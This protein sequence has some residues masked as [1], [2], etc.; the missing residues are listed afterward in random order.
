[1]GSV[2]GIYRLEGMSCASCAGSIQT[3]LSATEGIRE[4]SVN[5]ASEQVMVEYDPAVIPLEAI[6]KAVESLGFKMITRDLSTEEESDLVTRRLGLLKRRTVASAVLT[7]P[8][9][10]LAMVF[11]HLPYANPVMLILTLP[12]LVWS[13][14]EFFVI[15]WKRMVHRSA[16]MDT[17]VALGT[18][19]AFT[20][21]LFNT[22]FPSWLRARGI[23]PHVY[24]EAASVIITFILLGR[25][26]EEK[27]KQKTSGAIKQLMGLGVK[28]ARVVRNGVEKEM[29]ITKIVKG[30][31]LIIR[32][33][34]KI[35]VD[36]RVT[37]G[38]SSVD[39]SMITGESVPVNK[40]PG[41]RVIGATINHTGSLTMVA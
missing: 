39:E 16:N 29:L 35:P 37:E 19:S 15:A 1:M 11:H 21:S 3:L 30:D 20:L 31:V 38:F 2:K 18:G 12:V 14:R 17:L 27:A 41:E 33:G 24:Y 6:T 22:L 25:Y 8:V 4:A 10:I 40:W 23:E 9:V 13:G 34:E 7:L 32:P 26:F 36:G 28:T 5:L